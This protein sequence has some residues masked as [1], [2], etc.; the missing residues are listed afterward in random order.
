LGDAVASA[1]PARGDR[2]DE[3]VKRRRGDYD[4]EHDY[5]YDDDYEHEHEQERRLAI[6]E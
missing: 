5:D 2:N 4:Y 3:T 1:A 6:F